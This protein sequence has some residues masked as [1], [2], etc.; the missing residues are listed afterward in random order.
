M[1]F[2]FSLNL[3][4]RTISSASCLPFLLIDWISNH[5]SST[6]IIGANQRWPVTDTD[7]VTSG[8]SFRTCRWLWQATPPWWTVRPPLYGRPCGPTPRLVFE[9]DIEAH[10]WHRYTTMMSRWR[11][12]VV[13]ILVTVSGLQFQVKKTSFN[14]TTNRCSSKAPRLGQTRVWR[15]PQWRSFVVFFGKFQGLFKKELVKKESTLQHNRPAALHSHKTRPG[16]RPRPR[17]TRVWCTPQGVKNG[18]VSSLFSKPIE[19][20]KNEA[21][22]LDPVCLSRGTRELHALSRYILI[23]GNLKDPSILGP[24]HKTPDLLSLHPKLRQRNLKLL[25]LEESKMEAQ[26]ATNKETRRTCSRFF[27]EFPATGFTDRVVSTQ[28]AFFVKA[29]RL[30][31]T[32]RGHAPVMH[33]LDY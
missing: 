3:F 17:Q 1:H 29:L 23:Y 6:W 10:H 31:T 7:S 25:K 20:A 2:L 26:S 19:K 8:L 32:C 21:Y 14:F 16:S 12:C 4:W 28:R 27:W 24:I 9:G 30:F 5:R 11:S 33:D 13:S 15:T 22:F 18:H